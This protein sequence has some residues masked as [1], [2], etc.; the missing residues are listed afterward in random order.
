[1]NKASSSLELFLKKK[2]E[3]GFYSHYLVS[4]GSLQKGASLPVELQ[5]SFTENV[6]DLAS[7]T[8]AV[9][10]TPLVLQSLSKMTEHKALGISY[11][12]WLEKARS[13]FTAKSKS[14]P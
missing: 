1:M 10:T 11:G 3:E 8:K 12:D 7:L 2:Q 5:D 13:F 14:Y 4:Y 9:V 6:F